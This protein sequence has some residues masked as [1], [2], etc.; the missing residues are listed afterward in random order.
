MPR[1]LRPLLPALLALAAASAAPAA[2]S[3][4]RATTWEVRSELRITSGQGGFAGQLDDADGLGVSL[5]AADVDGDG[6]RELVA[7]VPGDDDVGLDR[8]GLYVLFLAEDG[9]VERQVKLRPGLNGLGVALDDDDFFGRGL[10]AIGDLDEDGV[11]DLLIGA[12]RDDDGGT[13]AGAVYV[14]FLRA[15]GTVKA[16]QK[17]SALHGGFTGALDA[18]DLFGVRLGALGDLDGDGVLDVAVGAAF[19]DDGGAE[20]GAVWILFLN[21]D[22]T[23]KAH[24]KIS[25]T[26]GGFPGTLVNGDAFGSGL[27]SPGDVDGDGVRDLAVGSRGNDANGDGAGA[28]W[29]LLLNPDGTVREAQVLDG[30]HG[31]FRG[32][33]DD[34]DNFGIAV[35]GLGDVDGDGHASIAVGAF[36]DDDGGT[37]RG[38]V[39]LLK[40]ERDGT[41]RSWRKLSDTRGGF[42]G[43]LADED[44]F[45][46]GVAALGDLDGDGGLE[47]AVGAWNDRSGGTAGGAAWI[48]HLASP[49]GARAASGPLAAAPGA[50]AAPTADDLRIDAPE[51][52]APG[53]RWRASARAPAGAPPALVAVSIAGLP[54]LLAAGPGALALALPD[55]PSLVGIELEVRALVALEGE[56]RDAP[57]VRV[58][59]VPKAPAAP[60][61]GSRAPR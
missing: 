49:A 25:A 24:R 30:V 55:D 44:G 41:A 37:D 14:L 45:G 50:P 54:G 31:G 52:V 2:Q 47:L 9:S 46:T 42:G 32:D 59:V 38:A 56:L 12:Y 22:G 36:W 23:V 34:D 3:V 35:D 48:L 19:D 8:G 6:R 29:I 11:T 58:R 13:N 1:S 60:P 27:C 53:E 4:R 5:I 15:D 43:P 21:P 61:A 10:T 20:A 33:L 16:H 40:L 28:V 51:E 7:A 26:S 57:P 39:W 18:N 17:I